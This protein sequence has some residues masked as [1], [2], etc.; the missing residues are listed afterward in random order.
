MP[1]PSSHRVLK[2]RRTKNLCKRLKPG[3]IALIHHTDLDTTAARALR[4]CRVAAVVNAVPSISGRYP[5]R[6]PLT[7][8]DAGIP[9][10]DNIGEESFERVTD[11]A[12]ALLED[13]SLRFPEGVCVVGER[14]TPERVSE[15]MEGARANLDTELDRFARN[16]LD[17][18]SREKALLFETVEVPHLKTRVAGK[19]VLIVVRGEGYKD[20][21]ALLGDYLGDVR[22][23]VIAVDG[24]AD[25]V[26]EARLRPDIILGDMDS[27]SDAALGCGA[28]LIV[29]GYDRAD[30]HDAPGLERIQK[31]GLSATVFHT[32]GTSEDAAMLLA[33][34]L[35]ARLIVAVGTHFSLEEFLDKGRGGMASTFLTRLRIGSKLVD[36]KGIAR[37]WEHQRPHLRELALVLFAAATPIVA[38][39][40]LS[41]AGRNWLRMVGVSFGLHFK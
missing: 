31:L 36:A 24:G 2:D 13:D 18:L 20:D 41:P 37:L 11:G 32:R 21:L 19:H 7:L 8:V 10:I 35:D 30:R 15:M 1:A 23:V 3:D 34:A 26:L 14:L 5:N 12:T 16:T 40:L 17:Y 22:P 6:G 38:V 4:D 33:D 9:F 28:E 25:A 39:L 29:H 27:V